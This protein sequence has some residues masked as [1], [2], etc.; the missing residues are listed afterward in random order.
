MEFGPDKAALFSDMMLT[1][2]L[3][4]VAGTTTDLRTLVA[5]LR[6]KSPWIVLDVAATIAKQDGKPFAT[7]RREAFMAA[8]R[9]TQRGAK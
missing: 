3:W 1:P 7:C 2:W 6:A 4:A 5:T 8:I 9:A